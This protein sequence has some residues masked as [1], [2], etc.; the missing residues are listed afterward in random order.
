MA[1]TLDDLYTDLPFGRHVTKLMLTG[2]QI[3]TVL[4]Q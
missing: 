1:I 4:E 3:K 2:Q